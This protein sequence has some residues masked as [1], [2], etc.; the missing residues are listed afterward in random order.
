ME[1]FALVRLEQT[2]RCAAS[3]AKPA[4]PRPKGLSA[5]VGAGGVHADPAHA[6]CSGLRLAVFGVTRA[7]PL[8]AL[9]LGVSPIETTCRQT[10]TE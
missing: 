3:P 9:S 7:V 6:E 4:P 8:L 10:S 2:E 5:S 1:L